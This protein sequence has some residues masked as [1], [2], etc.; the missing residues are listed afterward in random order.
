MTMARV[1]GTAAILALAVGA[2]AHAAEP[3][4][5][6]ALALGASI[7][8]AGE[9]MKNVDGKE[10]SIADVKGAKGTLVVFTC[11]ACPWAKA[12]EDRIVALGNDY[13]KKGIGVIAINSNDPGKVAEDAYEPMKSR[14]TEKGFAFPY[15]VD[16]TS[17][18]ARAFGATRTPEAFLF[19]SK[20]ALVYHG[21]IDDNAQEPAKVK[22]R[23]LAD[24]LNA[25]ATGA[26]ISTKET[27][28]LG[29]GIKFRA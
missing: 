18:V 29:C 23:Y 15:V 5:P 10:I 12:W 4:A 19:D 20:G 1:L 22:D 25:L 17:G 26:E 8:K 27:K 28:A 16:A 6:A 3:A 7:P 9:K 24:A 11:N 13:Q 21:T 2:V 14:A